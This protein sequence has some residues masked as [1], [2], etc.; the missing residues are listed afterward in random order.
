MWDFDEIWFSKSL[1]SRHIF[2]LNVITHAK[3][4]Q[5]S[6]N[7]GLFGLNCTSIN[8]LNNIANLLYFVWVSKKK[9]RNFYRVIC[10]CILPATI[11]F[12]HAWLWKEG[13]NHWMQADTDSKQKST[14]SI[15]N[16]NSF[17]LYYMVESRIL[18]YHILFHKQ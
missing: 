14:S 13:H 2:Q 5:N 12:F 4:F 17:K 15:W 7:T 18:Y 16:S 3:K 1:C 11:F 6:C 10:N 9:H 8:S